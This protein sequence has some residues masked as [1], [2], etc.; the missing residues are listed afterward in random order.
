MAAADRLPLPNTPSSARIAWSANNRL[1]AVYSALHAFW[2]ARSAAAGNARRDAYSAIL[3][4]DMMTT[5]FENDFTST[6]DQLLELLLPIMA[7]GENDFDGA[8]EAAQEVMERFWS[9]ERYLLGILPQPAE[10]T[11]ETGHQL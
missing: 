9:P 2:T 1:G 8:L 5:C 4:D 10:L 6:P 11:V 3:H 7:S